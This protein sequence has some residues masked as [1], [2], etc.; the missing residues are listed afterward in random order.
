MSFLMAARPNTDAAV[1]FS[2]G[3]YRLTLVVVVV[4]VVTSVGT[5]RLGDSRQTPSKHTAIKMRRHHRVAAANDGGRRGII[6]GV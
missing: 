2:D 6:D 5:L 3:C 1:S 4:V